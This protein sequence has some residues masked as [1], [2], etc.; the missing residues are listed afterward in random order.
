LYQEKSA[1]PAQVYS[2]WQEDREMGRRKEIIKRGENDSARKRLT[3]RVAR[4]LVFQ[5]KI[6]IWEKFSGSQIGKCWYILAIWYIHGH[7]G[8]FMTIWHM[9][10]SFGTFFYEKKNLATLLTMYVGTN[11]QRKELLAA[12]RGKH[13]TSAVGHSGPPRGKKRLE[14]NKYFS[15]YVPMCIPICSTF[16]VIFSNDR[17]H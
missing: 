15:T 17:E 1:T 13:L 7:L 3:I 12:R 4:W 10:C 16:Y 9:V 11:W 2:G 14:A 5:Q 8:Y 6:P